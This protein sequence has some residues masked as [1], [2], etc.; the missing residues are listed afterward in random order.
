ML[1]Q[2]SH[3][4]SVATVGGEMEVQLIDR[5]FFCTFAEIDNQ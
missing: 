4:S 5:S 1:V 3:E 2:A